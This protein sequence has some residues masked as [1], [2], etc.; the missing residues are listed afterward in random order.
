MCHN[1]T[2]F[3]NTVTGSSGGKIISDMSLFG[4]KSPFI[5]PWLCL[6]QKLFFCLFTPNIY[7]QFMFYS[8]LI[9]K[10]KCL[11]LFSLALASCL[12][13]MM[14]QSNQWKT[15]INWKKKKRESRALV[16]GAHRMCVS[17]FLAPQFCDI[18]WKRLSSAR[19]C[20][21]LFHFF[22]SGIKWNA[23]L[24]FLRSTPSALSH[25]LF[26]WC[27]ILVDDLRLLGISGIHREYHCHGDTEATSGVK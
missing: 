3:N 14:S 20:I 1:C 21:Y 23:V 27:A 13:A 6:K 9:I 24:R 22:A 25:F 12:L 5:K 11:F 19:F 15:I 10:K 16:N 7:Q 18:Y 2:S 4:F 26:Y 17:L 8:W